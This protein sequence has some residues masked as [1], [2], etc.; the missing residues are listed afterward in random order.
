MNKLLWANWARLRRY[1]AFWLTLAG[2]FSS[3]F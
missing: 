1:K 3:P 2:V